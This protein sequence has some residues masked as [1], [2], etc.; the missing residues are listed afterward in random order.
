VCADASPAHDGNPVARQVIAQRDD[1]EQ[2]QPEDPAPQTI[3]IPP[4]F[5]V[6]FQ[7]IDIVDVIL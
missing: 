4:D 6:K 2:H 7:P 3:Q 1:Q 5:V